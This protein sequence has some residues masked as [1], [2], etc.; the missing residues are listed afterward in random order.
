MPGYSIF[1][2][3]TAS[4]YTA[5]H[6]KWLFKGT[7][8]TDLTD[9]GGP[10]GL[11][12]LKWTTYDWAVGQNLGTT[13]EVTGGIW[14]RAGDGSSWPDRGLYLMTVSSGDTD[15]SLISLVLGTN[16][17]LEVWMTPDGVADK[18]NETGATVLTN[19][20][21]NRVEFR[22]TESTQGGSLNADGTYAVYVDGQQVMT[23]TGL[24]IGDYGFDWG[25]LYL[26]PYA[27]NGGRANTLLYMNE[28]YYLGDDPL[29]GLIT[30]PHFKTWRVERLDP[31]GAGNYT[32]W[33]AAGGSSNY[34]QVDDAADPDGDSSY[35]VTS[36]VNA[37]DTYTMSD[38]VATQGH[39][40]YVQ[41]VGSSKRTASVLSVSPRA[42]LRYGGTDATG[43]D[44]GQLTT[45][46]YGLDQQ[47]LSPFTSTEWTFAEVNGLEAGVIATSSGSPPDTAR[48]TQLL[49]EVLVTD[50]TR[51]RSFA[52]VIQ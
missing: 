21:E 11:R 26:G 41:A 27:T 52:S 22:V 13:T 45:Y 49:V 17:N 15:D 23:G 1:F 44:Y 40:R 14:L 6:T 29:S 28:I 31:T 37:K 43:N 42:L 7:P 9:T 36:T 12:A 8:P 2:V 33:T 24:T 4:H 20:G 47:N 25:R 51:R 39:I 46:R 16:G 3:D 10:H 48:L 18:I 50:E 34:L 19:G 30:V 35:V 32:Q 38:L 5:D